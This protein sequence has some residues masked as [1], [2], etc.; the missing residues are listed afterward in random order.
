MKKLI[1]TLFAAALI[2]V[3]CN[4]TSEKEKAEQDSIAAADAADSL[5]NAA[6]QADTLTVDSLAADSVVIDSVQ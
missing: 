3:A 6:M 4:N 1:F 5:L 2:T